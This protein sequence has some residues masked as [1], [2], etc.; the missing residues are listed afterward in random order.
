MSRIEG[1]PNSYGDEAAGLREQAR[2][3]RLEAQRLVGR[4]MDLE[5][6]ERDGAPY[7]GPV[8]QGQSTDGLVQGAG[9][10]AFCNATD[11]RMV[12]RGTSVTFGG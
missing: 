1:N 9:P 10:P 12:D 2:V 6:L 8:E 5:Q 11:F 3:L 4:A 7:P